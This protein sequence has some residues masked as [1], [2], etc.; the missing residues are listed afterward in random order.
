[1]ASNKP[2]KLTLRAY[3]V[4]FGDCFLLTFHYAKFERHVLIDFGST[5]Q[6]KGSG[7]K[8]MSRVAT[9]IQKECGGKLH[10]V[11]ATHRH[12]DHI[13][14]FS[15]SGGKN[16]SGTIIAGCDPDLVIQPW[17]EDPDANP[18]T[19]KVK[20]SNA[21][22]F[23]FGTALQDMHAISAAVLD[24]VDRRK[25]AIGQQLHRELS[26]LGED[27]LSNLSAVKN[28]MEMGRGKNKEGKPKKATYANFG[29]KTGLEALL[30]GVKIKVLGPPTLDQTEEIRTMK[31]KDEEEFWHFQAVA[32]RFV[33]K[34]SARLFHGAG[35]YPASRM[36]PS[37]RWFIDRMKSIRGEQLLSI[38]RALDKVMNNT[39]LIL[40]FEVAGKKFL[41]PG[42]AQIENWSY[43]L[44]KPAIRKSL[45][46]VNLYKVGH[47]ASLNATPKSLWKL[48]KNRS[49][50]ATPGRL[51]TV[52]STMGGKHGSPPKTEVPRRPLVE[53]L[54]QESD[55]FTTQDLKGVKNIRKDIVVTL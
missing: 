48:F 10:A 32:G 24:E 26:F 43:A 39:S 33:T 44:S 50:K 20:S 1:M 53:A 14:G 3:Q 47:H 38:M 2:N 34:P 19:G 42:D 21:N 7:E 51:Q 30:P 18:I 13:S 52:V 22:Q 46:G 15:T 40:L 41:F 36:P 55:F 37:T 35:T 12:K 23:A 16:A 49:T 6:P 8:L 27:N 5:G 31:S 17:T 54:K 25:G 29:S 4:G 9:D 28:L 45:E 11:V